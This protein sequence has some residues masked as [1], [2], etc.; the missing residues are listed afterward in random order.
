MTETRLTPQDAL[1]LAIQ[2]H[3]AGRID[4]A[5]GIYRQLVAVVPEMADAWHLLGVARLQ[6]GDAPQAI[7]LINQAIQRA[8]GMADYH[9]NLS[10]ALRANRQPVEAVQAAQTALQLN[11]QQLAARN[12]LGLAYLE[13]GRAAEAIEALQV[14]VQQRPDYVKGWNNLGAAFKAAGRYAEAIAALQRAL[15]IQ[16]QEPVVELLL[17][18]VRRAM[19]QPE[20]ALPHVEAAL[21]MAPHL[22]GARIVQANVLRELGRYD[23]AEAV[24]RQV[25]QQQPADPDA[26]TG[27]GVLLADR[28]RHSESIH[29][30]EQALAANPDYLPAL[31][32]AALAWRL[33]GRLTQAENA[34][35]RALALQPQRAESWANLGFVLK[36]QSRID[37]ALEA[38]DQ[39]LKL[40]P[41]NPAV[42]SNR[43]MDM[44]YRWP[45]LPAADLR[46]AHDDWAAR[47]ALALPARPPFRARVVGEP[48]RMGYVSP[49]LREHPVAYLL[50]GVLAHHDRRRV[51]ITCYAQ[52]AAPDA[53]TAS[54]QAQADTWRNIAGMPDAEVARLIRE[55]GIDLLVDLAGHSAR[56]RLSVFALRP[57]PVAATWL[58]YFNTTGLPAID[59][60]LTDLHSSP[61]E[62]A[63]YRE[64]PLYL[65]G[66]RFC[67]Q[68][69]AHA[70]D[71]APAP[72]LQRGHVTFGSFNN[73]AKL[74]DAVVALWA[75]VLQQVPTARLVLKTAELEDAALQ[76]SCRQRFAAHGIDPARLDLRGYSPHAAM[77]AE[78]ADVDIALDPFP[79]TG[80]MT[81]LEALWMGVPV[82]T[83]AGDSMVSRQ[84]AAILG[85]LGLQDWIATSPEDYAARAVYAAQPPRAGLTHLRGSLRTRMGESLL[86]D[87]ARFTANL[88]ALLLE[89][90]ARL[91]SAGRLGI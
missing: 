49:D 3:Q 69:P 48:L 1:R 89:A 25:V 54:L 15:A 73:Y 5:E 23:E 27:Y 81:T 79:F 9:A 17:A 45:P 88:E 83:L 30:H 7:E 71:P 43:L 22:P 38:I 64:T 87:A 39:S 2:H 4:E 26:W 35:R 51:H 60:I 72:S 24:F 32:N 36:A 12:G 13:L 77:L 20:A 50:S 68:P 47:F 37:E 16:P 59:Y 41:H 8:P 14:A 11:P 74:N 75:A 61:P 66:C 91:E 34:L 53:M 62:Q 42:A 86:G 40:S 63:N 65:P 55:D 19:R 70:P 56:H 76:A 28:G 33:Q 58:G 84:G 21:R 67:Y 78:Y 85:T 31:N 82:L 57:A 29:A 18:E 10:E 52:V 44:H 90:Y 6:R 80:G 46:A